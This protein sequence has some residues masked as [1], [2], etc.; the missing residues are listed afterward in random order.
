VFVAAAHLENYVNKDLKALPRMRIRAGPH[1]RR[2]SPTSAPKLLC[3]RRWRATCSSSG[4]GSMQPILRTFCRSTASLPLCAA[5]PNSLALVL[6]GSRLGPWRMDAG[7]AARYKC[8]TCAAPRRMLCATWRCGRSHATWHRARCACDRNASA[9]H[10]RVGRVATRKKP[11][12]P[13]LLRRRRLQNV[14]CGVSG[15]RGTRLG[16]PQVKLG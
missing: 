6:T 7:A 9:S 15:V 16:P 11:T 5:L 10:I 2:D 8:C 14:H 13:R 1:R 12:S 3:T 4:C